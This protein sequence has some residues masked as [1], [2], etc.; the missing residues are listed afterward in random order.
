[1]EAYCL[2][3]LTGGKEMCAVE[4]R[5]LELSPTFQRQLLL[6]RTGGSELLRK[7]EA[8]THNG[9]FSLSLC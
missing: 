4:R 1:M 2:P 7:V 5:I 8:F 3:F 9:G 6:I